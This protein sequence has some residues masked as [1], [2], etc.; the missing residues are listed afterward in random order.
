MKKNKICYISLSAYKLF[1]NN[2]EVAFGG[3]EL[4]CYLRAAEIAKD[5]NFEVYF[6]VNDH[7]A[8]HRR[9]QIN[10]GTVLANARAKLAVIPLSRKR[11]HRATTCG[12]YASL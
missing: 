12:S 10:V 1:D 3:S 5:D 6:L 4:Q 11:H 9:R 2:S 7:L 8:Q